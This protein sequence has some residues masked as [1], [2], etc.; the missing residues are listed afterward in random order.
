MCDNDG[1]VCP[2]VTHVFKNCRFYQC[3]SNMLCQIPIAVAYAVPNSG[4]RL[5]KTETQS[6][7][8]LFLEIW[9]CIIYSKSVCYAGICD[10]GHG[11]QVFEKYY[12]I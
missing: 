6:K 3:V 4:F 10:I 1:H 11:N 2:K 7:N 12:Y 8:T 5:Q 9:Q